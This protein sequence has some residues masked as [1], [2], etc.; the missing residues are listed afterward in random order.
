MMTWGRQSEASAR[1]RLHDLTRLVSDWVWETDAIGRF[2]HASPRV[3]DVLGLLPEELIGRRFTDMEDGAAVQHLLDARRP[4]R[5]QSCTLRDRRGGARVMLISALPLYHP[6]T[7]AFQGMRGTGRDVTEQVSAQA[8]LTAQIGFQ[9]AVLDAVPAPLFHRG[10][11]G[12]FTLVNAAFAAM[13]GRPRD[14]LLGA[15]VFDV[16]PTDVAQHIATAEA[17]LRDHG[18]HR[19]G[20]FVDRLPWADGSRREVIVTLATTDAATPEGTAETNR[21]R[22]GLIGVITEIR[23]TRALREPSPA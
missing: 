3:R 4:F 21:A 8:A 5:D 16:F 6:D 14:A 11:D 12:R 15:T 18:G 10:A 19:S 2:T 20:T 17:D 22:R 9:Q 7:G 23:H 13:T 1:L